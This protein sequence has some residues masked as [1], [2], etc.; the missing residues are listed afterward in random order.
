MH[1]VKAKLCETHR[2]YAPSLQS[3]KPI[4]KNLVQRTRFCV[5][6]DSTIPCDLPCDN[7]LPD[8][9]VV[10]MPL[11][12]LPEMAEVVLSMFAP[13][14]EGSLGKFIFVNI[15]D[16]LACEGLLQKVLPAMGTREAAAMKWRGCSTKQQ[17]QWR[18]LQKCSAHPAQNPCIYRISSGHEV[19]RSC[20]TTI[21]VH[22]D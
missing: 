20:A 10:T 22:A 15:I 6:V 16:H 21:R 8:V 2:M 3:L 19:L 9:M 18:G 1:C 14:L 17:L 7:V 12:S 5:M 11:S 4:P 13:E